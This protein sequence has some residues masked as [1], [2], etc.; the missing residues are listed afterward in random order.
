MKY[1]FRFEEPDT[2]FIKSYPRTIDSS[3]RGDKKKRKDK[4]AAQ[5][6]KKQKEKD[7]RKQELNRLKN[8]KQQ[9]IEEKLSSILQKSGAAHM[10]FTSDDLDD[11]FDPEEHDKKMRVSHG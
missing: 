2:E 9:E 10:P 8:L 7:K 6:E 5:K 11:D 1:N 4:R 3:L